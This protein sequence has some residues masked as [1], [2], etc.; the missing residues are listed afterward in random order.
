MQQL[1]AHSIDHRPR[2]PAHVLLGALALAWWPLPASPAPPGEY[3]SPLIDESTP[4]HRVDIEID[5]KGAKQLVLEVRD[6]GNGSG[7]DW[8]DWIEP[9]LVGP[10]GELELTELSWK[11]SEGRAQVGKNQG[12]GPLRVDGKPVSSGIGV[13]APSVLVFDLPDGYERFVA[14]GGLDNGGTDQPGS[15]TSVVF[16]AHTKSRGVLA[17]LAE[18]FHAEVLYNADL[19]KVG[20]W[21]ALGV[22]G[23]GRLVT[24]DRQGPL[25]R[26][27][28]PPIGSEGDTKVERIDVEVG[29]ANGFLQAFGSLYVVGKGSGS[30]KG[31][32]GLWRL[33]DTKDDDRYD[34]VEFLIPLRVGAD[35]HA[36]SVLLHP[37]GKRLAVLSGNNTD[38]PEEMS[39]RHIRFQ[40]EDHLLP[41][42]TYYGHNTN[43]QAPGGFVIICQPDGSDRRLHCAGFRNPYD[44]AYN[45]DGELFTWDA[46]MEYDVGGPW[47]RPTRVNHTVS[48]ADFGWRWG[49][50]KWPN[51]YPDTVGS[52]VDI[53]R[54]SPTGVTFGYG[55]R[56]PAR[57]Q[58]A[59]FIS[60]WTYGRMFA[61]HL[62]PSGATYTGEAELFLEGRGNPISDVVIRPQDG[63]LY[64][65]TGGRRQKTRLVRITYRGDEPT[66]L[67]AH[68]EPTGREAE[69]RALRRRLESFHGNTDPQ[70]VDTAWPQLSHEDRA[71]RFA[72]RTAIEHQPVDTWS[73]RALDH[74]DPVASIEL[75][76]ALTRAGSATHR[77]GL[78]ARLN[79]LDWKGLA[80]EQK[81]DLLR[82]YGLAFIRLGEPD[83][84]TC[85]HLI[86]SLSPMFPAGILSLDRELGQM[87]LYLR[88]PGAASRSVERLLAAESQAEEMFWA[89]HLRT[90]REGL[91]DADLA[92]YL[93]WLNHAE[94]KRSDYVGGGH[95]QNFLKL[96]RREVTAGLSDEQKGTLADAL[97][98]QGSLPQRPKL[99]RKFVRKWTLDELRPALARVESGRSFL[100]GKKISDALCTNCHLFKGQGGALG[101][102][103]S[104]VG[105]KMNYEALLVEI[106][107][108]SRVISDQ[109]TSYTLVLRDGRTV[110]GRELGGDEKV[111]R[112]AA[113]AQKPEEVLEIPRADIVVRRKSPVSLMPADLLNVLEEE[114]ILDLLM[115]LASGG[116]SSHTAFDR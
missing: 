87:L 49:A 42:A 59:L 53:G 6:G 64:Y 97:E 94:A 23:K 82:A 10:K 25:Y 81:L 116:S 114:E 67:V 45:R 106:L 30:Q 22:D 41:R 96:V 66:A 14:Q 78:L 70:A 21:V 80:L 13:H 11:H 105:G 109:H 24:A 29:G 65:V 76:V 71:I 100:R 35:H 4:G 33:T 113:N 12:G 57:Y 90:V 115:Y 93:G 2:P 19:G 26:I 43:R 5:I 48:G 95:F 18:G 110:V 89:Y 107:D 103:L 51:W 84:T 9:R 40:K 38:V 3:K 102:D 77:A 36:H 75:A 47:Y 46:D 44:F 1:G 16:Y 32:D 58:D 72:A 101:P 85:E 79:E 99:E 34:K 39:T 108:P 37:D 88:A 55:A 15:H 69:L 20:S 50:G 31:R 83:G 73:T 74:P 7:Y 8:A 60:D 98:K 104:S 56:F 52:V 27:V 63:A 17:K 68:Q 111:L 62:S 91:T 54:G 28:V 112:V 61:V 86:S 92:A